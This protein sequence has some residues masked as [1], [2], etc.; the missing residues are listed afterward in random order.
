MIHRSF[1]PEKNELS[2]TSDD[3]FSDSERS[4][5]PSHIKDGSDEMRS[6]LHTAIDRFLNQTLL[7]V[8]NLYKI[9]FTIN[10]LQQLLLAKGIRSSRIQVLLRES[11]F[12]ASYWCFSSRR[13][14]WDLWKCHN[15][16]G[17]QH[18]S[19]RCSLG[20]GAARCCC[21]LFPFPSC[22]FVLWFSFH[23]L[24]M[25]MMLKPFD[26]A[27][28]FNVCR[29]LSLC[30]KPHCWNIPDEVEDMIVEDIKTDTPFKISTLVEL[31]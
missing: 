17:I 25:V 20:L 9:V 19:V 6:G 10:N 4:Q 11:E 15:H 7:I 18:S 5:S 28:C 21:L 1:S 12:M 14:H 2:E 31:L 23:I 13:G 22:T 29:Y 26:K 24:T 3:I 30:T 16:E 27:N 8:M